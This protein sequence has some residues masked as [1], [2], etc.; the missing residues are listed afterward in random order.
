MPGFIAT[1]K[2]YYATATTTTRLLFDHA[3]TSVIF[4]LN[5]MIRVAL[6]EVP[7]AQDSV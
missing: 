7:V 4:A 6:K 5:M 2:K 1:I 3:W